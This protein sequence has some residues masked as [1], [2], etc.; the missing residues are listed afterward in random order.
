MAASHVALE[1]HEQAA[2]VVNACRDVLPGIHIQDLER[3]PLKDPDKM[4]KLREQL[5]Q[6]GY[7][8]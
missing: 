6:A 1:Q 4:N 3:I 7:S 5:R 8:G 2:L